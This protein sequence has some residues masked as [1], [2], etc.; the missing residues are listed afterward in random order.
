MNHAPSDS[1]AVEAILKEARSHLVSNLVLSADRAICR[2]LAVLGS[3]Q[4]HIAQ[5]EAE[6][7]RMAI[8]MGKQA[9]EIERLEAA[10]REIRRAVTAPKTNEFAIG[11][12]HEITSRILS[13]RD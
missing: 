6:I 9:D 10:I 1:G 5:H 11:Q 12:V 3:A 7:R 8:D 13:R 4:T 2:A